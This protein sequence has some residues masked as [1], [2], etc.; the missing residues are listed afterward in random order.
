MAMLVSQFSYSGII[1]AASAAPPE[2]LL[3]QLSS[4]DYLDFTTNTATNN[5]ALESGS[6][7]GYAVGNV[8]R[9]KSVLSKN[10]NT[11]DALVKIV[12]KDSTATLNL[13]DDDPAGKSADILRRF[14]P[15]VST[16]GGAGGILF[17]ISFVKSGTSDPVYLKGFYLTAID[18]DG[19][20]SYQEY[21]E[22]GGFS[23]YEIGNKNSSNSNYRSKLTI[24]DANT[25]PTSDRPS[26]GRTR[27]KGILSSLPDV[28]FDNSASFI[29][30]YEA[31]VQKIT[32][33]IGNTGTLNNGNGL[34]R[35][36][37]LNFGAPGGVFGDPQIINNADS[38]TIN[39]TVNDG[40]D[41]KLS[42]AEKSAVVISGTT[43]KAAVND[44]VTLTIE[45]TSGKVLTFTTNIQS[46]GSYT[47]TVDLSS[48]ATGAITVTASVVNANGNP[49]APA[50]DT[51]EITNAP[52]VA[53]NVQVSGT[54]TVGEVLTGSYTYGDTDNDLEDTPAY[55]W[56]RGDNANG[57][58]KTEIGGATSASYTLTAEDQGKYIFFEV[59]PKAK[60]GVLVGSPVVSAAVGPIAAA[61]V[62][63]VATGDTKQTNMN[64]AVSGT[65]SASDA[66]GDTLTYSKVTDPAHG[67]VT[68]NSNGTYTYTPNA[69][70]TGPDS[71][72]F[73]AY[74]GKAYSNMAT[75]TIEVNAP[76]VATNVQVSGTPTV[77]ETLTGSYTYGDADNDLEDTPAYKWYRGDSA[78]GTG[79][80]AIG[81][82]TSASYTLTAE[83]QG[84][85]IFF[86][87]MPKAK[88]GVLVG[89]PAVSAAA[90]PIAAANVAPVATGDTK[91]TNMNTAVSGTLSASDA[92][93]D[94]LTYS[95]VTDPANGTVTVNANGTYTYTP[96]AGY[97]GPDSFTFKA[98]DGKAYSNTAT[99]TVEVNAPPVATNVQVSGTPTVGETL[100]GSYTYGD[101]DNDLEDTPAYKWYRGDN[102]NG[103]GKTAIGGATS[104]SYTLTAEDQGKYIFF[105]V[106][107]KAK[108]GVLIG[109]PVVSAAAGPIAAA[110]VA[111]VATGDTKQT[112][113]N[114]AVSGTLSASDANGD[115]L[116]YSKVTDPANGT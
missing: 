102:A 94:T 8:Y 112:N 55:K 105:E 88:T 3:V 78:N 107:P 87:V 95:K 23:S 2:P 63:P 86:E 91:Q 57:T 79:K 1:P 89:S 68:V 51:S 62:A 73:K 110:N 77:G 114:T 98:Y 24:Y 6:S 93:G 29:A 74:D 20:N 109:S 19:N 28:N 83:D 67:T 41:G 70:Y 81:G 50:T 52:P 31:P 30:H 97:T 26:D 47:K 75:V 9:Y 4:T 7:S 46:G 92:N 12:S 58:G 35:Q 115:T 14:N 104:A 32:V 113:M 60:T 76:P 5:P 33:V 49:S 27:F 101:A 34:G 64:T 44:V 99:V 53:T 116:T 11:V 21:A 72:T 106:T 111:P 13:L 15:T 69:G 80:T 42:A 45:D 103:T 90:G 54:S 39:V 61:N 84:K 38:P 82:A 85:Y 25:T 10:G 16:S 96:N 71:F 36:F 108:T 48:L 66:N 17:Q 18:L 22:V 59:T 40:G 56:Y 65:L 37:S 100:T 43:T